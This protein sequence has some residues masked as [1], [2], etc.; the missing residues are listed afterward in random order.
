MKQLTSLFVLPNF[1][2]S[3]TIT[4]LVMYSGLSPLP[5]LEIGIPITIFEHIFT[6][7]GNRDTNHYHQEGSKGLF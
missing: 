1:K 3:K 5:G 7:Q 4:E 2:G 6:K